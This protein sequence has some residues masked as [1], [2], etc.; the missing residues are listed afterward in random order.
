MV[1]KDH[2]SEGC[3]GSWETVVEF[4]RFPGRGFRLRQRLA[5]I[6][7][8]AECPHCV[9][10]GKPG[11]AKGIIGLNLDGLLVVPAGIFI[12]SDDPI[13]VATQVGVVSFRI[14]V[15]GDGVRRRC[16][17]QASSDGSGG[18]VGQRSNIVGVAV[19][20]FGP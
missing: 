8:T 9:I 6:N 5:G 10:V 12:S 18:I 14:D 16:T 3:M 13:V 2:A 7:F 19:V 4:D 1:E 20:A 17:V 11:P 15:A